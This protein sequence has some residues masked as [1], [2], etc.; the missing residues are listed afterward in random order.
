M[1]CLA[2]GLLAGALCLKL[3]S[4]SACAVP[5]D[6]FPEGFTF[7]LCPLTVRLDSGASYLEDRFQT[8]AGLSVTCSRAACSAGGVCRPKQPAPGGQ[9]APSLPGAQLLL[10]QV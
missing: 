6:I 7:T 3:G 9:V 8:V 2:L 4:F 10:S 1:C 5:P